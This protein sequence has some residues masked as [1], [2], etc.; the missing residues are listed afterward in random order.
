MNMQ[1]NE[2]F[3]ATIVWQQD[4]RACA[5][6]REKSQEEGLF[7]PGSRRAKTLT[8]KKYISVDQI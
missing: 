7:N 8:V 2:T 4:V 1:Q 6:H 3:N 5:G